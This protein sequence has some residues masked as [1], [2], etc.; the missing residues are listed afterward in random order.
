MLPPPPPVAFESISTLCERGQH[1]LDRVHV[2]ALAGDFRRLL[3][4]LL[5]LR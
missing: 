2:E 5:E 3:V 1:A 4:G